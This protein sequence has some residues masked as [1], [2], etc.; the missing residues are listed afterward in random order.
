M[1]IETE[2]QEISLESKDIIHLGMIAGIVDE[3]GI[4]EEINRLLGTDEREKIDAG[5]VVK[6]MILNCLG[7]LTAPLY[8]FHHFFLGKPVEHLLGKGVKAEHLNDD[9]LGRVLDKLHEFGLTEIFMALALKAVKKFGILC[10]KK[11]LD[12]TSFHVHGEYA[13]AQEE[14]EQEIQIKKGHSKDHRPDLNQFMVDIFVSSDGDVPLFF[15]AANGNSSD[16]KEFPKLIKAFQEQWTF[17][18]TELFI[19]DAALYSKENIE[20]LGEIPWLTRVP[21]TVGEAKEL[22]EK[23]QETELKVSETEDY[24]LREYES[25][26]GNVKQRWLL[27]QNDK[28]REAELEKFEKKLEKQ[29][30]ADEKALKKLSQ[31]KFACVKEA[32][33]AAQQLNNKLKYHRLAKIENVENHHYEKAG[34]PSKATQPAQVN[35][36]IKACLV[37][38][39]EVIEATKNQTGRFVLATNQLNES[40]KDETETKKQFTNDELLKEYKNQ[41]SV[42]RGFRF[43]KDPLFFAP[44][45]FVKTARR[46]AALAMIMALCL[47]VYTIGQRMLRQS[48]LEQG[49][50][51]PN[52]L[53][54]PTQR[55]TLRWIFQCFQSVHLIWIEGRKII[56]N[57]T[58]LAQRI[59]QFFCPSCREYYLIE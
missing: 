21:M 39:Q 46:V 33:K 58:E 44:S 59:L 54:K 43:L 55:P 14:K 7:F 8:L 27:I 24:R 47:L 34:R 57:L 41:Q 36:S 42:E 13:Q 48:L 25:N 2:K 9:R 19:A 51:L 35:Y 28:R 12:S 50:T 52:Q 4:A 26:Y 3:S 31:Q 30:E 6:A 5:R 16:S 11:H 20:G 32:E 1:E 56:S 40:Q 37:E 18:K 38:N 49:E 45:I 10:K 17:D 22:V 53:G 15:Q 23:T 29:R